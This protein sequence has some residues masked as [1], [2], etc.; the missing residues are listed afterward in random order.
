MYV[1]ET[2]Q[3]KN[4]PI[5]SPYCIKLASHIILLGRCTVKHPLRLQSCTL[6][7]MW[8]VPQKCYVF[9]GLH[10]ITSQMTAILKLTFVRIS[11][12][13]NCSHN[14]NRNCD[15]SSMKQE[16]QP[17]NCNTQSNSDDQETERIVI[18]YQPLSYLWHRNRKTAKKNYEL[19]R[20]QITSMVSCMTGNNNVFFFWRVQQSQTT[21]WN[22][23]NTCKPPTIV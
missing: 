22:I 18:L 20:Y 13:T 2:C 16:C 5:K 14:V 1:A 21:Q 15:L 6:K 23:T 4:T 7:M 11:N 9:T 10:S 12:R 17:A 3:A 8:C 19:D